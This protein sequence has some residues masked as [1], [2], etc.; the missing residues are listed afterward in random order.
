MSDETLDILKK[1]IEI[2]RNAQVGY[3]EAADLARN[4]GLKEFFSV[5]ALERARFAAQLER[6]ARGMG[7][8]GLGTG[9]SLA[10]RWI[11][12]KHKLGGGDASVLQSVEAG[13]TNARQQYQEALHVGLPP[14]VHAIVAGQAENVFAA[15]EQVRTL[16][17]MYKRAA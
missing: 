10:S 13:D 16:H 9:P 17:D 5:Q 7:G 12:L 11:G 15:L 4:A 3:L 8:T 1:L 6:A 2:C 14:E